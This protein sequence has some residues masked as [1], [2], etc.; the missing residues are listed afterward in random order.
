M[1][2]KREVNFLHGLLAI[3][4][5]LGVFTLFSTIYCI[6]DIWQNQSMNDNIFE[7]IYMG[8]HLIVLVFLI[9]VTLSAF[10]RGSFIMRGLVYSAYEG[11]SI[12]FLVVVG[13][14]FLVGLFLFIYG[15]LIVIPTGVYDFKFPITLK[16]AIL[17]AGLLLVFLMGAFFSF[18]FLFAKNPTLTKKEEIEKNERKK[19]R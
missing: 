5:I 7:L 9:M 19:Q 12:P 14:I 18:P 17:N 15:L 16:W 1:V 4:I 11:V 3:W 8:I 13:F 6:V 2:T 10:K